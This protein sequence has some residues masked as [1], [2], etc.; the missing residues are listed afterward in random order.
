MA[1]RVSVV[2]YDLVGKRIVDAVLCQEDMELVGVLND[3]PQ[4]RCLIAAQ[5]LPLVKPVGNSLFGNAHVVVVCRSDYPVSGVPVVYAS[6]LSSEEGV[7]FSPLTRPEHVFHQPR[8]RIALPD[9]IALARLVKALSPLARVERL[10]AS[11][12][13]RSGHATQPA[14]GS[15][16]SLEPLSADG[17][18]TSQLA[19][20][21]RHVVG[22]FYVSRVRS[23]Y[24]HSHLHTVKLD[25]DVAVERQAALEALRGAPRVLVAAAGEGFSTTADVQEFFRNSTRRRADRPE[26]LVWEESVMTDRRQLY[27]LADVCQEATSIPE[28]VDAIRLSQSRCVDAAESIRRTDAALG[29]GRLWESAST[30]DNEVGAAIPSLAGKQALAGATANDQGA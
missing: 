23:P 10:Y 9:V 25:L 15:V 29:I 7:L 19:Q 30:A 27:L 2:G 26:L 28:T 1:I 14:G 17:P 24:T 18:A 11:V 20:V 4:H 16:D 12:I 21:L 6:H 22:S 3:D 8:V 13:T 5:G